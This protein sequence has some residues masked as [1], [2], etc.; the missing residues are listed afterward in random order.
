M[1]TIKDLYISTLGERVP[2]LDSGSQLKEGKATPTTCPLLTGGG[3]GD[4]R[5]QS[6]KKK[7]KIRRKDFSIFFLF[8]LPACYP[9]WQ[10]QD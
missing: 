9:K 10:M 1:E 6:Q 5:T 3:E 2:V 4:Y 7:N 8:S